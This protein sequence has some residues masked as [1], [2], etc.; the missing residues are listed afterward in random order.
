[1]ARSLPEDPLIRSL[2]QQARRA[3]LSRRSLLVG[4]A[5]GASALAL[6]ACAPTGSAK[7]T[8]AADVSDS[9]KVLNWANWPAYMDEDDDGNYPTLEAFQ[10]ATGIQVNYNVEV[11]DNNT[12]FAKYRD[13]LAL[14]QDIGADTVCL[15]D[16]MVN[17]WIRQG[18]TQEIDHANI[19]NLVNLEPGLVDVS[20]DPGRK[21]SIPWQGGFAG[22]A[23]NLEKVPAGLKSVADLWNPEFK[24]RVGV[25]SEMRDT[26]GILMMAEGIDI[27]G[28]FTEAD[29]QKAMDVFREQVESGQIRNVKGNAYLDDLSNEDTLV[30]IVWSGDISV[31]NAE[32]DEPKFGFALPDSGGTLWYDNFLVPIGAPHKANAEKV[33][34]W[35]YQP[36]IAAELAA[37]VNYISPVV[38]AKEAMESIEPDYVDNQLIFPDEDTLSQVKMFRALSAAEE[39]SFQQA[40]SSVLLGA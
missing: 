24:G 33:I 29:F 4:G 25:L 20:F 30:A 1:M 40:F 10:D 11:D 14:G 32:Y 18:Y 27:S 9:E 16:W 37:W 31:L 3:Q 6:A 13:Q 2:V 39:Q 38:G 17:R 7:P 36:E 22:L 19:P 34:D 5:A 26:I 23:W 35:Y 12:Y 28:D 8:A 15:T 21:Y